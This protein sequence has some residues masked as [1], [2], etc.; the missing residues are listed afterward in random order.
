M[1]VA[2]QP[3]KA[4]AKLDHRLLY[5]DY[6]GKISGGRGFVMRWDGGDLQWRKIESG[7]RIAQICGH[8]LKGL[9]TLQKQSE[10]VWQFTI[11][12]SL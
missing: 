12:E 2:E 9:L 8:R 6:E 5:L 7:C 3:M 1:P 10:E 4:I 11:E